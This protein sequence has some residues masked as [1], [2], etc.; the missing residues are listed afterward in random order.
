MSEKKQNIIEQPVISALYRNVLIS[1]TA[2]EKS[3]AAVPPTIAQKEVRV[4]ASS[5]TETLPPNQTTFLSS[6]L[7]ACN[8]PMDDIDLVCIPNMGMAGLNLL[9][10]QNYS[11]TLMFGVA[12]EQIGLP[13]RF[14]HFQIQS[15][16]KNIYLSAPDLS[17]IEQ[18]KKLKVD[19]WHSLQ[20]IFM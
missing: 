6:I 7:K 11:K 5:S 3:L 14:P 12:P 16:E 9:S 13:I 17:S 20:K 1:P 10:Q 19:L 18:D 2:R 4:L 15:F 8:I